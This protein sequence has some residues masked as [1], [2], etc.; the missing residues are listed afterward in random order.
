MI[1]RSAVDKL[2]LLFTENWGFSGGQLGQINRAKG[3]DRVVREGRG[4][5]E[6]GRAED[7]NGDR[8]GGGG[9]GREEE[10]GG[11]GGTV[12]AAGEKSHK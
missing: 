7:E 5:G 1:G 8:G 6:G 3:I 2:L 9:R 12:V 11:G 4:G 10:D